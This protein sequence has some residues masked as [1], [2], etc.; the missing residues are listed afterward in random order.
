MS[1]VILD[2][3]KS[4]DA[5]DEG[6]ALVLAHAKQFRT[7]LYQYGENLPHG[8][9]GKCEDIRAVWPHPHPHSHNAWGACWRAMIRWGWFELLPGQVHLEDKTSHAHRSYLYKRVWRW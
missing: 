4:R 6:I 5:R 9:I 2:L 1:A 8:W 7:D 3:A